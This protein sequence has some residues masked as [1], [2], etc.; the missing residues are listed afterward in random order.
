LLIDIRGADIAID[1][2]GL[3]LKKTACGTGIFCWTPDISDGEAVKWL[4]IHKSYNKN[5]QQAVINQ[6]KI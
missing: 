4:N 6:I 2:A 5:N 1:Q 3:R